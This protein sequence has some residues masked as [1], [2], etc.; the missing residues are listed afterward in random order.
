MTTPSDHIR[1]QR[2]RSRLVLVLLFAMFLAPLLMAVFLYYS[3]WQ[4]TRTRNLGTLLQPARD[5]RP[6]NLRN[7]DGSAFV[8]DHSDHSFRVVVAPPTHCGDRCA[9]LG[10][11]LRRIWI[12]VGR[13]ADRVQVLWVGAPPPPM[14][15]F[16]ALRVLQANPAL[17]AQ[18][19]D[20]ADPNAVAV[21]VADPTGYLILRYSPGFEPSWL[22]KD[23]VQL[24]K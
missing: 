24:L 16:G 22:R 7:A 1:A 3:G 12:G 17:Q 18:L 21:Y 9:Q 6:L 10:D 5:L 4:P 11:K 19:A 2:T 13:E 23:L 20:P 14:V 15:D 8:W